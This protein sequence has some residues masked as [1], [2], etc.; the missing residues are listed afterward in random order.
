VLT[1]RKCLVRKVIRKA[2][3]IISTYRKR[4]KYNKVGIKLNPTHGMGN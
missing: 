2:P 3:E 4:R 1:I